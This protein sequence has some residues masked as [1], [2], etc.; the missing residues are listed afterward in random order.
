MELLINNKLANEKLINCKNELKIIKG[1]IDKDKLSL[2]NK[3]LIEY[4]IVFSSASIEV[5]VKTI[6]AD[7]VSMNVNAHAKNYLD[8][9]IRNNSM[10]PSLSKI[11]AM[12]TEI[13]KEWRTSVDKKILE[14][15]KRDEITTSLDNIVKNRNSI[16][17]GRSVQATINNVIKWVDDSIEIIKIIDETVIIE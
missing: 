13:N 3:Y 7:T 2:S 8:K 17:H 14:S 1:Q 15:T 4:A 6:I 11:R 12:L 9:A 5:A 10:N 16:A